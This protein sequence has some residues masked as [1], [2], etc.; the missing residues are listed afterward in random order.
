MDLN[1]IAFCC[2]ISQSVENLE[3]LFIGIF[4][5]D[6]ILYIRTVEYISSECLLYKTVMSQCKIH[7]S[8]SLLL[9]VPGFKEFTHVTGLDPIL[10]N[11]SIT[12][13]V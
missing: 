1:L 12:N 9:N 3:G 6:L 8:Y 11:G 4:L 13:R 10:L 7:I 5:N 2:Q